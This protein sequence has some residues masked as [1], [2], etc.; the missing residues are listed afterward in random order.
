MFETRE[1]AG[2][3]LAEKL[4][5]CGHPGVVVLG[6]PRGGVPVAKIIA[7][8]LEAP[9]GLV[10]TKKI[11]APG[12]EELAIGAV[13]PKGEAVLDDEL[14]ERLGITGKE[15]QKQIQKSKVKIR[16]YKSKFKSEVDLKKKAVILVDDGVATGATVEVAIKHLRGKKV[17]QIVL[18]LPVGPKDTIKR[19]NRLVD[20]IV[21]L[22]TPPDFLAVGQFYR[23]FP[24]ITDEEVIELLQ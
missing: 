13:G 14:I 16:K 5:A 7:N 12:H 17:G 20:K 10:V 1:Q 18:A 21:V 3:L 19:L 24:Q 6:I 8:R 4:L 22:E 2:E 9:L 11:S 15:L 23:D